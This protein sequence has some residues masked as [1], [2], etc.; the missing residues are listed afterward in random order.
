MP[1]PPLRTSSS[2][3]QQPPIKKRKV[4]ASQQ[5]Q[6]QQQKSPGNDHHQNTKTKK[7]K[8]TKKNRPNLLVSFSSDDSSD[9]DKIGWQ[10]DTTTGDE[11]DGNVTTDDEYDDDRDDDD[12]T[13][14]VLDSPE[15]SIPL[16]SST[17]TI[18]GESQ[19]STSSPVPLLATQALSVS[20][21]TTAGVERTIVTSQDLGTTTTTATTSTSR[22]LAESKEW[23][24]PTTHRHRNQSRA[25]RSNGSSDDND[26]HD[27]DDDDDDVDYHDTVTNYRKPPIKKRKAR[28]ATPGRK[29]QRTSKGNTSNRPARSALPIDTVDENDTKSNN[30]YNDDD[31]D[32]DLFLD[33]K[34][35]H[36]N[37]SAKNANQ[38][39]VSLKN[40]L[41]T[42]T[43]TTTTAFDHPTP[44]TVKTNN[45]SPTK[46]SNKTSKTTTT[47]TTTTTTTT[48]TPTIAPILHQDST[49]SLR[50]DKTSSANTS[51][52]SVIDLTSTDVGTGTPS[53]PSSPTLRHSVPIQSAT[54]TITT[55]NTSP[56]HPPPKRSSPRFQKTTIG[57]PNTRTDRGILAMVSGENNGE[58]IA[59]A[60]RNTNT[61]PVTV[62]TTNPP[63]RSVLLCNTQDSLAH[64]IETGKDG[65]D[66]TVAAPP[67]SRRRRKTL[68][69]ACTTATA[70]EA[71]TTLEINDSDTDVCIVRDHGGRNMEKMETVNL[72]SIPSYYNDGVT[73]A[74]SD[75]SNHKRNQAHGNQNNNNDTKSTKQ[76]E[77]G[78][79]NPKSRKAKPANE[80]SSRTASS[81][82]SSPNRQAISSKNIGMDHPSAPIERGKALNSTVA[83]VPIESEVN[84]QPTLD[85]TIMIE[86]N[87]SMNPVS[88]VVASVNNDCHINQTMD[89]SES[90]ALAVS[91]TATTT[92]TTKVP[93]KKTKRS[94]QDQVLQH[95]LLAY[96]PFSLK[97]L[98]GELHTTE[99]ALHFLMLSLLDKNA[100]I[101]KE[102]SNGNRSKELYWVN[103]DAPIKELRA[104]QATL[105]EIRT[106]QK[107]HDELQDELD[108][109]SSILVNLLGG[110]SNEELFEQLER[111]EKEL[112]QIRERVR[113]VRDRTATMTQ[114]SMNGKQSPKESCPRRLKVR[115]NRMR[116]EWKTRKDKCMEFVDQLA[117]G[118]EKKVKDVVKLLDI[119]TDEEVGVKIPPKLSID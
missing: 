30:N 63:S 73:G 3:H 38:L 18:M 49:R 52:G 99:S 78:K 96:K 51:L 46:T 28:A 13:T 55:A 82:M 61:H 22:T 85:D 34:V 94:F 97:M 10:T 59:A 56:C 11:E 43:T 114:S 106:T 95:M 74:D 71:T 27:D 75:F 26:D 53:S 40:T 119:E 104:M 107:E 65:L 92:S 76:K 50:C 68:P 35:F 39:N 23:S 112:V 60:Q 33:Y 1:S 93:P 6:Q 80:K 31:D 118:M 62:T 19:F 25:A 44:I 98:A 64:I 77:N 48:T 100:V 36:S 7:T 116:D 66:R 9:D 45:R 41:T 86:Q 89:A 20:S 58:V 57:E 5:Q 101:K 54:T 84:K 29:P 111:E 103:Y 8:K 70:A 37:P 110:P 79:V 81:T 105:E 72:Q 21:L 17:A 83:Y 108:S 2:K 87:Q 69:L 14:L 4:T 42:D 12:V 32:A 115:I 88:S 67:D 16:N 47:S 102:F 113:L 91:P 90:Q 15:G 109:M 24:A 117:D